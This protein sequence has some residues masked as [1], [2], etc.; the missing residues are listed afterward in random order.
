MPSEHARHWALDPRVDFLTHGTYGAAPR[1]VLEAQQAWR[2]RLEEEPVR[3]MAE[4]YEPALDAAR[5]SL[6][7]FIGANPEDLAF[8]PNATAGVNT[9]LRS[10]RFEPGDELITIDHAY[11]AVRNAM[12]YVAQRDGAR[13]VVAEVPFPIT[14][15][16]EVPQAVLAAVTDRT[17]LV[18]LDHVTSATALVLPVATLIADLAERGIDT[19][20]DGA[21]APGMLDLDV[22]A[23]GATYYTGNLHK[24]V[25]A[26]KGAGFLWVRR[27]RQEAIR[28]LVISHGANSP[29][30][31]R[32]RFRLEFDW[33]G[34]GDPAAWLAVPAAIDF[35]G[36]LLPGGWPALRR[37]NH[38]LALE[39]R[40]LLA[41]AIGLVA[42]APDDMIGTMASLPLDWER[43][44]GTGQ[45]V[46]LY[47]DKVHGALLA[48][49]FQVA[50]I[51][52]PL[53]PQGRRW[54]RLLRIS[55]AAYND[56]SQFE[57]LAAA[58]PAIL[59]A[60]A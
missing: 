4:A 45:D 5:H 8:L 26:P 54:R 37:R 40:D 30:T 56:R 28:P 17:R 7:A 34:T 12:A 18:V 55:A 38:E 43:E 14:A 44:P 25:C 50:A 27:D 15:A 19:L 21:H 32:S 23:L 41:T 46:E 60:A 53:R 11:N 36:A 13:V 29:R 48:A 49:G 35:G 6:G 24:W 1:V 42:P 58:L 16:K 51:P 39:A 22:A 59:A 20:I 31:D 10:L 33:Q 3:F 57:R 47:G 52:W 2:A 9:V